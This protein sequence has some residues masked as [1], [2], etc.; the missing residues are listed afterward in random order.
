[1]PNCARS[2]IIATINQKAFYVDQQ[3]KSIWSV[4][5]PEKLILNYDK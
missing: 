5:D 2:P 3:Q 4:P 1:M